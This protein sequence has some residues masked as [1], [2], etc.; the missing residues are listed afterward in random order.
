MSPWIL[1]QGAKQRGPFVL[2]VTAMKCIVAFLILLSLPAS[3]RDVSLAIGDSDINFPVDVGYV[4]VRGG[5]PR[6]FAV[7]SALAAGGQTLI[8]EYSTP[9]DLKR[10][11]AGAKPQNI[12]YAVFTLFPLTA[13]PIGDEQWPRIKRLLASPMSASGTN[14]DIAKKAPEIDQRAS[15]AIGQP[16]KLEIRLSSDPT[17]YRE[18]ERSVSFAMTGSRRVQA[19]GKSTTI[20]AAGAYVFIHHKVLVISAQ[21]LDPE[22]NAMKSL[23]AHLDPIVDRVIAM[24]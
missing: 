7:Q 21:Q 23:R 2:S 16:T 22:P 13:H 19:N 15:Q 10:L 6:A 1:L 18:T 24:N 9:G 17:V 11:D 4:S 20:A 14:H 8:E 12:V 5:S 3:A